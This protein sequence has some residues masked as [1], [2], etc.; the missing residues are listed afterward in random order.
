MI[1]I[2]IV[3]DHRVVAEALAAY[4]EADPELDVVGIAGTVA[5]AV[6]Q[7]DE[8]RPRLVLLDW[9]LSD[10]TGADA[11]SRI[12]A[13]QPEAILLFLSAE[14]SDEAGLAGIETGAH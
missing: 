11:A 5:E 7:A 12:R 1:S 2:L 14:D 6:A 4:L 9:R 10:G 3:E 13:T 8:R